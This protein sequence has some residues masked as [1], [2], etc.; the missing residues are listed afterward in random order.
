MS[1]IDEKPRRIV[2][3]EELKQL[4]EMWL[5]EQCHLDTIRADERERL[6]AWVQHSEERAAAIIEGIMEAARETQGM[7]QEYDRPQSRL[8]RIKE[9]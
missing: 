5:E 9:D 2:Q 7:F 3:R 4:K 8:D 1:G 6:E